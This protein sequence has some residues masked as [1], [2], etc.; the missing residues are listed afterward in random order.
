MRI[1]YENLHRR[2][3]D[4]SKV[5]ESHRYLQVRINKIFVVVFTLEVHSRCAC[6]CVQ[7]S[8]REQITDVLFIYTDHEDTEVKQSLCFVF[9]QI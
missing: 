7:Y 9:S 8:I 3:R 5:K 1:M 2:L 6:G 4:G